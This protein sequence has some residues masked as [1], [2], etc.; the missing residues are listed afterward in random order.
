M[1]NRCEYFGSEYY[2]EPNECEA[3]SIDGILTPEQEDK[4]FKATDGYFGEPLDKSLFSKNKEHD[5][6]DKPF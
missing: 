6:N 4:I 5:E 1:W 2:Y 3:F